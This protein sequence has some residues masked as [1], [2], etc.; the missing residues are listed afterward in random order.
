METKIAADDNER[1]V[2]AEKY[3][4]TRGVNGTSRNFKVPG[5]GPY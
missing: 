3:I 5:D 4:T 1:S 2:G